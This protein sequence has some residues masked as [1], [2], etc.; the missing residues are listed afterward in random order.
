MW[1]IGEALIRVSI[2]QSITNPPSTSRHPPSAMLVRKH[3]TKKILFLEE[4]F[5]KLD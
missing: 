3:F 1:P 4:I 2:P 5:Q